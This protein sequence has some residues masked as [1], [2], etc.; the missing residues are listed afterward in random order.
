MSAAPPLTD[1][2]ALRRIAEW[3]SG[4]GLSALEVESGGSRLR[5]RVAA[6]A[7]VA[8]V[9]APPA[10][11]AARADAPVLRAGGFGLLLWRHPA[12]REP[13]VA[14]GQAVTAGQVVGLL[15]TGTIY[16]PL[17]ADRSGVVAELLVEEGEMLGY[18]SPV[19]A[20]DPA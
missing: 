5:V 1:P 11:V 9:G 14:V 3:L 18:G 16:A 6:G 13:F 2:A 7:P 4:A 10:A 8:P 12:R 20:L 19:L 17:R 15:R